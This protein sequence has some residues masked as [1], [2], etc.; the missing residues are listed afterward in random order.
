MSVKQAAAEIRRAEFDFHSRPRDHEWFRARQ[1]ALDELVDRVEE[2]VAEG[3]AE[4]PPPIRRRAERLLE[5][6]YGQAPPW[7]ADVEDPRALLDHLFIAEGS[8]RRSVFPDVEI[9]LDEPA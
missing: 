2:L 1:H 3:A 5:L 4:V 9:E 7:F 6:V 8:L